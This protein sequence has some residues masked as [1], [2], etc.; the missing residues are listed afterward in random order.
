MEVQQNLG[1][2]LRPLEGK[3]AAPEA[4]VSAETAAAAGVAAE[5]AAVPAMVAMVAMAEPTA[6]AAA[7][8]AMVAMAGPT[9]VAVE[10]MA[11]ARAAPRV[12]PV[13]A[14]PTAVTVAL[15]PTGVIHP[16]KPSLPLGAFH[17][18]PGRTAS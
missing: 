11:A 5:A 16:Q 8:P 13:T 7:V 4:S 17:K 18:S 9:A 3:R 10:R 12:W 15:G 6:E 14:E 2:T 1:T